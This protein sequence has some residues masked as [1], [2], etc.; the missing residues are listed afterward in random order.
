MT[1]SNGTKKMKGKGQKGYVQEI[2]VVLENVPKPQSLNEQI[3]V[4]V[5]VAL[6]GAA[7]V[8]LCRKVLKKFSKRKAKKN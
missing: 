4:G 2:Q 7:A 1:T 8:H 6:L 3:A 5:V